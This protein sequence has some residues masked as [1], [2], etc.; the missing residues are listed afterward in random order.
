M[1]A[2]ITVTFNNINY[3]YII[4]ENCR[5]IRALKIFLLKKFNQDNIK[6]YYDNLIVVQDEKMLKDSEY[7]DHLK[8]NYDIIIK[9]IECNDH[10]KPSPETN[11]DMT[12]NSGY[13]NLI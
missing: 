5:T 11:D 9:S 8:T 2:L 4:P 6:Y 7:L 13:C 10:L 1:N 12:Q 3:S